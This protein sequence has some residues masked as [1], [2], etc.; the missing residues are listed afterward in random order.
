VVH[1]H[2]RAQTDRK[3]NL[4]RGIRQFFSSLKQG[5]CHLEVHD[6]Y[7]SRSVLVQLKADPASQLTPADHV[8]TISGSGVDVLSISYNS[9]SSSYTV[10]VFK[11]SKNGLLQHAWR[12][13]CRPPSPLPLREG[14]QVEII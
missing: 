14:R 10:C 7:A 3:T 6:K 4:E 8:D 5:K 1:G 9:F 12:T 11:Q 13:G 2:D